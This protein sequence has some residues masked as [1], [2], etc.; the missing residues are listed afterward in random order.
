M[1]AILQVDGGV[2][3]ET[4]SEIVPCGPAPQTTVAEL[5]EVDGTGKKVPPVTLQ[6]YVVQFHL[7][8]QVVRLHQLVILRPLKRFTSFRLPY[9]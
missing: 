2:Q 8:F 7:V 9:Q 4:L 3:P 5:L 1:V 6:L